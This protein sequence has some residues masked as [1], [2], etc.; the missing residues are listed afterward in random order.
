MARRSIKTMAAKMAESG[1]SPGKD[2]LDDTDLTDDPI[3]SALQ[4]LRATIDDMQYN[5]ENHGAD[6]VTLTG[7]SGAGLPTRAGV[8]GSGTLWNNR[9][10]LSI[11]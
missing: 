7:L 9:G 2:I 3:I 1:R 10:V 11:S 6:R 5:D 8:R 4:T